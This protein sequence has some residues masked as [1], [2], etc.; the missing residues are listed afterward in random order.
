[1]AAADPRQREPAAL[2]G[3]VRLDGLARIVRA[4]RQMPAIDPEQRRD[5]EAVERRSARAAAPW[6]SARRAARSPLRARRMVLDMLCRMRRPSAAARFASIWRSRPPPRRTRAASRHAG[7]CSR[8]P[9]RAR[10]DR[11]ICLAGGGP[12][13]FSI[14]RIAAPTARNSAGAGADHLAP[15]HRGRRLAEQAGL[16]ALAIVGHHVALHGEVDRDRAAAE[17]RM[18][19]CRGFRRG[20]P[21]RPRQ[22]GGKLEDALAID[23]FGKRHGYLGRQARLAG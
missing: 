9:A 2:P 8:A 18:G 19:R 22:G 11:P 7:L 16:H 14:L 15:H 6:R 4:A 21:R 5:G 12:P 17:L 10:R 13:S 3:A 20:E 23:V 1:M